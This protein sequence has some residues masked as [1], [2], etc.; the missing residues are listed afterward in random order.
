MPGQYMKEP[1][2]F[3]FYLEGRLE[4]RRYG[5]SALSEHAFNVNKPAPRKTGG[6][7]GEFGHQPATAQ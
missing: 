2:W 5:K 7:E 3:E 6:L 4:G 1:N